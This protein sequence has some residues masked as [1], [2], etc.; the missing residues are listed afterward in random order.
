LGDIYV[1]EVHLV[2]L[3][4]VGFAVVLMVVLFEALLLAMVGLFAE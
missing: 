3:E 4:H 1:H 2:R